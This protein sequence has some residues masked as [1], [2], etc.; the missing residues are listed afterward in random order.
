[1]SDNT[2]K[3]H[4]DI[5]VPLSSLSSSSKRKHQAH[6]YQTRLHQLGY[7]GIAFCHT[8]HGRLNLDRDD[9]DVALPWKDILPSAMKNDTNNSTEEN[10]FGRTNNCSRMK[11]YRRLNIVVE[12]VSDLS[13]ILLPT[14]STIADGTSSSVR[15][16]LQKYDIIS[17][18]PM[19]EPALQNI[20]ELI[21][22]SSSSSSS[23]GVTN[24][25][26]SSNNTNYIDILVLEY[27]TGSRG[28]Y[29]LPYKLRKE[30]VV[31]ALQAGVT[32]ELCYGTAILDPKRRQGFSRTLI[33]F[34][35]NYNSIQKKHSLQ[36]KR[37]P[38]NKCKSDKF[39]LLLSSGPRQNF[40]QGTDEGALALR[41]PDDVKCLVCHLGGDDGWLE[42]GGYD[43]QV[44][45]DGSGG[46]GNHRKRKNRHTTQVVVSAAE[47]VLARASDRALGVVITHQHSSQSKR[48]RTG[49]DGRSHVIG[50]KG[51]RN[52]AMERNHIDSGD[53]EEE[54]GDG[55]ACRKGAVS[56]LVH[57]LSK[58]L[59]KKTHEEELSKMRENESSVA[60][61]ETNKG[62]IQAGAEGSK[63]LDGTISSA[64]EKK[65][66]DFQVDEEDLED[67]FI[68]L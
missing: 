40:T 65:S 32:F 48:K 42:K 53:D 29:G 4:Y 22:S 15:E 14:N 11:I 55:S 67:G 25:T 34:Q 27:A 49:W 6:L 17:L 18:Q 39:P 63:L 30:Y 62:G 44:D 26:A 68:A 46:D 57:W 10:S 9:A 33:D 21:S 41:S 52:D 64:L 24:S 2:R 56:S 23:G 47:K 38:Q 60:P 35:S 20:C 31:K 45:N 51:T 16:L 5:N 50:T 61:I 7:H 58:P 59:L 8:A 54:D 66:E 3:L 28:G 19:N 37:Y 12:E 43:A 1:M 13:R 36:N